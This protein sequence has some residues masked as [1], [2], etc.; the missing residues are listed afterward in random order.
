MP[1]LDPT[2]GY[3]IIIGFAV[4]FAI[5]AAHK[6][7]NL[8]HFTDVFAAYDLLPASLG[9]RVAWLIPCLELLVAVSLLRSA[10][11]GPQAVLAA[12]AL[13]IAYAA[14]LGINLRRGRH[15]LDCGCVAGR[16]PRSM[17]YWMVWRNIILALALGSD[18]LPWSSRALEG[19]DLLTIFSAVTVGAMLYAMVD[20][21]L[22]EVI[23]GTIA[24]RRIS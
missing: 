24:L 11:E 8:R 19:A 20:R 1:Q 3:S 12:M 15:D 9:R 4:L 7:V 16:G 23:P 2:F 17:A 13:L 14:A 10:H 18:A 6:L 22:G 5:A 21:L